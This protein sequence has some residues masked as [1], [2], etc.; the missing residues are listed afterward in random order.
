MAYLWAW[1]MVC[2]IKGRTRRPRVLKSKEL[3]MLFGLKREE[4]TGT[5]NKLH[6]EELHDWYWVVTRR[7]MRWMGHVAWHTVNRRNTGIWWGNLKERENL[8]DL[9]V[10]RR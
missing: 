5:F 6:N 1:N 7:R 9:E 3:R 2:H 10:M 4:I 8:K